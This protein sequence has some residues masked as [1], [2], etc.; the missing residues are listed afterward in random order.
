VQQI[1]KME[2][3][4][5]AVVGCEDASFTRNEGM[6]ALFEGQKY[7]SIFNHAPEHLLSCWWLQKILKEEAK[8]NGEY[9]W[10]RAVVLQHLWTESSIEQHKRAFNE[11]C[12]RRPP[13]PNLKH[14]RQ[15]CSD[16]LRASIR[17]YMLNRGSGDD[18]QEVSAFFKR[19]TAY[20][21][22]AKFLRSAKGKTYRANYK[23]RLK[24]FDSAL[25]S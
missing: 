18:R 3:V 7:R 5:K 19:R 25:R 13:D 20:A 17:F 15:A 8:G 16:L 22:F 6:Q 1:V 10:S 11:L 23:D 2:D 12:G 14:L 9:A 24:R 21:E 4:A